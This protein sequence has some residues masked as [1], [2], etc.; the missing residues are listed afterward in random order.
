MNRKYKILGLFICILFLFQCIQYEVFIKNNDNMENYEKIKEITFTS[1]RTDKENELKDLIKEYEK[2]HENV[3]INLEL[4]G[5]AE[6]ILA[7]KISIGELSDVTLIPDMVQRNELDKY[8]IPIDDIGLNKYNMYNYNLGVGKDNKLYGISTSLFW[9]GVIYN[10]DIFKEAGINKVPETEE[11]LWDACRKIQQIGIVP[12]LINYKQP[13]IMSMWLDKIPALYNIDFKT[14]IVNN[15]YNILDKQSE[16]YRSLNLVRTIYNYGFCED[17]LINLD[18]NECKMNLVNKKAAMIIWNSDFVNQLVDNGMKKEE[19]GIFPVPGTKQIIISGDYKIGISKSTKNIELSKDFLK[20][21]FK[22]NRYAESINIVSGL[23]NSKENEMMMK[24]IS[25]YHIPYVFEADYID[26]DFGAKKNI[27]D[28]Y[29]EL[30]NRVGINYKFVQE[31][32]VSNNIYIDE[33]NKLWKEN[34]SRTKELLQ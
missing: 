3:K 24:Q 17:D 28:I 6:E 23:K 21:L 34:N 16:V 25:S 15:E 18:W 20:F 32:I 26:D 10:K 30:N 22:D 7:R 2:S 29:Y 9:N 11:E 4:I 14:N 33:K 5:N 12:I 31:Y 19:I 1:N 27:E 13:W 8:F